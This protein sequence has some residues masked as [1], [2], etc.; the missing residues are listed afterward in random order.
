[1]NIFATRTIRL[2]FLSTILLGVVACSTQKSI[3]AVHPEKVSGSPNCSECH[4]DSYGKLNHQNDFYARHKYFAAQNR[5]VCA[6]CHQEN[7]C[8]DCH[9]R[10]EEIKPSD[11][12]KDSPERALPHRGD[13]LFQHRIDGK[14]NP[15]SCVKC[16]G[17]TNNERCVT[18]HK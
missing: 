18:C 17:R 11:K 14:I 6:A 2:L 1:M 13:Y 4:T 10:R 15:A 8:N 5:Q 9:T 7:F 3:V 16:H 12:Y